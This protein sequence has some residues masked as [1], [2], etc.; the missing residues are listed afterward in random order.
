[1][2]NANEFFPGNLAAALDAAP[3]AIANVVTIT[4]SPNRPVQLL[5]NGR[6][7]T[8]ATGTPIVIATGI[9]PDITA[10]LDNAGGVVYEVTQE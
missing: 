1:M 5:I 7:I 9:L 8:L 4:E 6:Q 3:T 2:L 10:A